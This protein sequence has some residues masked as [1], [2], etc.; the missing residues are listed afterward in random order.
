MPVAARSRVIAPAPAA[1]G[2]GAGAGPPGDGGSGLGY[3]PGLDALRALAIALVFLHHTA[4]FLVPAW[5]SELLPAGFL[6]VDLFFVLSGF[7]ITSLLLERRSSEPHPLAR[8]YARRAL[9][10]LPAVY[11]LLAAVVL[12]ALARGD[13]RADALRS[14]LVVGTYWTNWAALAGVSVSSYVTHL[15]SLA[16]EEQFYAVWPVLLFAA[17]RLGA[18]RRRLVAGALALA[19]ASA[20]W[21]AVLWHHG[22]GWLRIYLRTDARA[23]SLLLGAALALAPWEDLAARAGR[24]GRAGVGCLGAVVLLAAA[25]G[26]SPSSPSLY[27]GGFTVVALG[28]AGLVV[29][30]ATTRAPRLWSTLPGRAVLGLGRLSY[31]LYLW[32]FPL[33]QVVAADTT[34]WSAPA[35]I[36]LAWAAALGAAMISRRWVER[37][38]LRLKDRWHGPAAGG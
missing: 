21:R 16:I 8:F 22:E 37:P 7:L 5:S 12:Y 34:R 23:D 35:R 20:A 2:A 13:G 33:F 24:L 30:A 19:L 14:V 27:E 6:G 26:L 4:A 38:A 32:H 25:E 10:L 31:S 18:G 3:R 15:W 28:C 11:V 17:L 36:A 9:R 1:P 29:A